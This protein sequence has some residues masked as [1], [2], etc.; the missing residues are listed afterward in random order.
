MRP[1]DVIGQLGKRQGGGIHLDRSRCH[2]HR[3]S[4]Q[5]HHD[6]LGIE[7]FAGTGGGE[8]LF[9]AATIIEAEAFENTG[10]CRLR[11]NNGSERGFTSEG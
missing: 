2:G 8:G 3:R 1:L 5:H 7:I 9:A 6:G 10:E 4:I 11:G